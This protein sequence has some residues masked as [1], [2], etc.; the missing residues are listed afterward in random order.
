MAEEITIGVLLPEVLGTYGDGGNAMVLKKRAEARG[1]PA[2]IVEISLDEA[3]P[4]GLDIYTMGGG[5]DTAQAL[6]SKKFAQDPGLYQAIAAQ[7]PLLAVCAGIQVLG[8]WFEDAQGRRVHGAGLL[9]CVTL[10]QGFRAIGELITE[11]A[12][13]GLEGLLSGFEN[14]GGATIIGADAKPLGK[15]LHGHGNGTAPGKSPSMVDG[16]VQGSVVATYMH[17]PILARNPH[18]ADWFLQQATGYEL[19][20]LEIPYVAELRKQRLAIL[21][22]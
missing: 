12:I 19:P 20:E 16:V 13:A 5:E 8:E 6:A 21:K 3:I 14:H 10:P 22:H 18:L 4:S 1:I 9:D 7:R 2:R 15:V 17:G 11:P